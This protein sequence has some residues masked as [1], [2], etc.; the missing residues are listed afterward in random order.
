MQITVRKGDSIWKLAKAN[1]PEGVALAEFV[2]QIIDANDLDD[3]DK[4]Q[5][6][7]VIEVPGLIEPPT[8]RTRPP[9]KLEVEA[10]TGTTEGAVVEAPA[11]EVKDPRILQMTER[12][13]ALTAQTQARLREDASRRAALHTERLLSQNMTKPIYARGPL[14]GEHMTA[15]AFVPLPR[16]RPAQVAQAMRFP[17]DSDRARFTVGDPG[18]LVE[19]GNVDLTVR[20]RVDNGDGTFSTIRSKSFEADGVEVLIPTLGPDGTSLSDDEAYDRYTAT[21]EHLGKFAS[22]EAATAYAKRLSLAMGGPEAGPGRDPDA[23]IDLGSPRWREVFVEGVNVARESNMQRRKTTKP[24]KVKR[25]QQY[26][27]EELRA[28]SDRLR[29]SQTIGTIQPTRAK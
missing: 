18:G 10:D 19:E 12:R 4:I 23:F 26:G 1:K 3:P 17:S 13:D 25:R 14:S 8:P 6:G 29:Q 28:F 15:E 11:L 22:T 21:G 5:I 9:A 20:P 24:P 27:T 7:Q 16:P 2:Q